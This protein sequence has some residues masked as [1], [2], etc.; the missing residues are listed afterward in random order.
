MADEPSEKFDP[1]A[2]VTQAQLRDAINLLVNLVL[3]M[4]LAETSTGPDREKH[5]SSVRAGMAALTARFGLN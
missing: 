1:D 5:I 4:S 2:P 3:D